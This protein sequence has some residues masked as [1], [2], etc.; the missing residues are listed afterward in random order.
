MSLMLNPKSD[1]DLCRLSSLKTKE[2]DSGLGREGKQSGKDESGQW[3]STPIPR[4]VNW[5]QRMSENF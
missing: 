4:K 1:V 2:V 3:T 5:I